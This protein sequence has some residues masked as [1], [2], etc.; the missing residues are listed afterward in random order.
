MDISNAE[1][2]DLV[3]WLQSQSSAL[4]NTYFQAQ[5]EKLRITK[6]EAH[7]SVK[8]SLQ[9][10]SSDKD[11]RKVF[12]S[13]RA[14]AIDAFVKQLRQANRGNLVNNFDMTTLSLPLEYSVMNNYWYAQAVKLLLR[15][16]EK[17]EKFF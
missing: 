14:R 3:D 5:V 13:T 2:P 7:K 10:I 8:R 12:E 17:R 15:L 6:S 9:N 4:K 11:F 1:T 16:E